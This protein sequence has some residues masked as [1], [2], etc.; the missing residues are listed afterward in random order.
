MATTPHD[1]TPGSSRHEGRRCSRT[2]GELFARAELAL[3]QGLDAH[4]EIAGLEDDSRAVGAGSVFVAVVGEKS[5]GH[6][7]IDQA[8][9]KGASLVVAEHAPDSSQTARLAGAN[10]A[11]P[12]VNAALPTKPSS[13]LVAGKLLLVGDTRAMLGRLAQAFWGN[14]S[15]L[16]RVVGITGTNGKTTIAYLV[17]GVLRNLRRFPVL[18]STVEYRLGGDKRAAPNTTPGAVQLARF[19]ATALERDADSVVMEVSSHSLVQRRVEAVHFEVGV[20]TNITQDHLDYHH[21]MDEYAEAKRLLFTR[22]RP[23][24]A[25]F[26]LD[27]ETSRRFAAEHEGPRVTFS[28][29]P[30]SKADVKARSLTTSAQGIEMVVE[31]APSPTV[32]GP[33]KALALRS[34]LR[35]RFNASNLLAAASAC[36]ALAITPEQIVQALTG[37]NGAPGR[38]EAV[39]AGQPFAVFVDYAHTPDAIERLLENVRPLT[40]GRVIAV[41][42][43]GGNRDA[44]KRPKMGAA[45][46]RMADYSVITSDNPRGEHPE[47]IAA[48]MEAGIR[49]TA[50]PDAYEVCLDR[51]EAIRH[52]LERA[53]PGDIVVVAGKGHETY[54]EIEG[55]RHPFDDREVVRQI[56]N[57]MGRK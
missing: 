56:L 24:V 39:Q 9:A 6:R 40:Q 45:M 52:A 44:T 17:E 22:Y 42:G 18:L 35:G 49:T 36:L 57:E 37:M 32:G 38:F 11:L 50:R 51:R 3:P 1:L 29:D 31:F 14:P 30:A 48:A 33:A 13:P 12:A 10:A 4:A 16:L 41:L 53:R 34:P 54:Q 25:V 7:F 23:R 15:Q 20:L 46:G 2:L 21:T 26:N 27:D 19:M 5:D 43:C 8:L 28:L 55:V 47:A